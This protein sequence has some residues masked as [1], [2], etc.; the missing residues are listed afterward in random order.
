M[1][2]LV[3][4]PACED[5]CRLALF[6]GDGMTD[7]QTLKTAA[8]AQHFAYASCAESPDFPDQDNATAYT[9]GNARA[10]VWRTQG[11]LVVGISGTDQM[12]DWLDNI[13]CTP[14]ALECGQAVHSGML[15]HTHKIATALRSV[16]PRD[17][18]TVILGSHSLGGACSILLPLVSPRWGEAIRR[19]GH[20][21]TF[22]APACL[23]ADTAGKYPYA[24]QVT[25]IIRSFDL[26]PDSPHRLHPADV[27]WAHVGHKLM[28][29]MDG[30]EYD[31]A[32]VSDHWRR[33]KRGVA[34][35]SMA[36][37]ATN[38]LEQWHDHREYMR[39]FDA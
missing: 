24:A 18:E 6:L 2:V 37:I 14:E 31:A 32:T 11:Q 4:G 23:R 1:V 35:Q 27:G 19:N 9:E 21:V 26:I 34:L 20:I 13:R 30:R 5:S 33:F 36:S 28:F 12:R 38:L 3:V 22:G 16:V 10:V 8:S 29:D 17:D 15:D 39:L 7:R 25:R